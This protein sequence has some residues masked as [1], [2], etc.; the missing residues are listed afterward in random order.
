MKAS[1]SSA[2][3]EDLRSIPVPPQGRS[4][5]AGRTSH[6]YASLDAMR[7]LAAFA[8]V[9][10]HLQRPYAPLAYVAVDFFFVL[11]GFV[12]ARAYSEKLASGMPLAAF[13]KARYARLY[14]LF[15]LGTFYG[16]VQ[17]LAHWNWSTDSVGDLLASLISTAFMLPS[18]S[19]LTRSATDLWPLYPLNGPAWS[20]FWELLVNLVFALML[21][22]MRT[23]YLA[24]VAAASLG[25]LLASV[26]LHR[27]LDLGWEWR[28]VDGG[29]A[30]VFFS[31]VVGMIIFRLQKDR[32][33][34]TTYFALLPISLIFALLFLPTYS[35]KFALFFCIVISPLIVLAGTYLE[36][37]ERIQPIGIF[38][39]YLSYP[40][41]MCHR[42]FTEIYEHFV[43]SDHMSPWIYIGGFLMLI[44]VISLLSAQLVS[45]VPRFAFSA[46]VRTP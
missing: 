13:M 12:I 37:P 11:S 26:A 41:Y 8:V 19:F 9:V 43:H 3:G 32:R 36:I 28:S 5:Q 42:G 20:L 17:L 34:V 31:F 39:G 29:L 30:R 10:Y 27:S 23:K 22:R 44:S 2:T 40:I 25:C 1:D 45:I 4:L 24:I 46:K 33:P 6:R 38:L 18:P 15:I 7:G 14:P 35:L 21:F 16:L